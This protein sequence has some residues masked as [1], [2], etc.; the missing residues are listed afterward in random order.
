MTE[1]DRPK[2]GLDEVVDWVIA[3]KKELP[4]TEQEL[5]RFLNERLMFQIS[6][7]PAVFEQLTDE[8]RQRIVFITDRY[9]KTCNEGIMPNQE[10]RELHLAL[11]EKVHPAVNR[12]LEAYF[13]FA[14]QVYDRNYRERYKSGSGAAIDSSRPR[15]LNEAVQTSNISLAEL[16][17]GLRGSPYQTQVQLGIIQ[18]P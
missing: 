5:K 9:V 18:N 10:E 15:Q 7:L 14:D 16:N 17:M 1:Q 11:F 8:Q 6:Y 3:G 4:R 13:D 12:Y 2:P